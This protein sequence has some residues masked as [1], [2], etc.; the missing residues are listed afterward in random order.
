MD[1]C[2]YIPNILT[3]VRRL[4]VAYCVF[5]TKYV[6]KIALFKLYFCFISFPIFTASVWA[7]VNW[8][9]WV[10]SRLW[11]LRQYAIFLKRKIVSW[12]LRCMFCWTFFFD[13][14]KATLKPK[15]GEK[16]KVGRTTEMRTS[17]KLSS[18]SKGQMSLNEVLPA[19]HWIC[20]YS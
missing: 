7:T 15:W 5:D 13:V 17:L 12:L 11:S 14:V 2:W 18:P 20:A 19:R 8:S 10:W 16:A 1:L 9:E 6:L 3:T 4:R